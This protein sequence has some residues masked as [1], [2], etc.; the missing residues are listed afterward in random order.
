[1]TM[2]GLLSRFSKRERASRA[3]ESGLQLRRSQQLAAA[4]HEYERAIRIDPTWAVPFYNLGLLHKYEGDWA[5]SLEANLRATEL[6]P[7][8]QAGWWNL[9]IAATA[10]ERWEV[11]RLAWRGA[12]FAEVPDGAGPLELPCGQTPVRLNPE[13]DAEVVWCQRLDPARARI[14]SIPLVDYCF[15][16]IVLNDGAAVGYRM[17]GEEKVPV[18]N[19]LELLEVS[20]F[21]TWVV[22]VEP[23]G[24]GS[25]EPKHLERLQ[26]LA[27]E[28]DLAAEDWSSSLQMLC[29]E[30]S[31]GIPHA[32]DEHHAPRVETTAPR[33]VAVAA[34]DE[35]EV[36]ALLDQWHPES[37]R[38]RIA[39]IELAFSR[40]D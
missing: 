25:V 14:E 5:L 38:A 10:L 39:S 13:G 29:K 6:D 9:G 16:D 20:P 8:D 22:L 17:L 26:E 7:N 33:R 35:A 28:R 30:C 24:P 31:E 36:R 18:F 40:D 15:G 12:G 1:M 4:I 21:S 27:Q 34:R 19:C 11:A 3:N 37:A 32:H 2:A 23:A